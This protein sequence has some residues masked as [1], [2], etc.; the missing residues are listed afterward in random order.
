MKKNELDM[1]I[2]ILQR[3]EQRYDSLFNEDGTTKWF[4]TDRSKSKTAA[5]EEIR[6]ARR[7]LLEVQKEL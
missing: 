4:C 6:F 2:R 5:A 7:L 1:A 3:V